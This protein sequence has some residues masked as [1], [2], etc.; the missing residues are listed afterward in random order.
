MLN[1]YQITEG[2]RFYD[3]YNCRFLEIKRCDHPS[4]AYLCS[5]KEEDGEDLIDVD[6]A[7]FTREELRGFEVLD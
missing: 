7:L 1:I 4:N 5:V 6:D 3:G 2:K